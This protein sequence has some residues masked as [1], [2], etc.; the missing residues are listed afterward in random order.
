M[1]LSARKPKRHGFT[2]VELLVLLALAAL[3]LGLLLPFLRRARASAGSV[4]C[5]N[6]LKQI[7]LAM[8]NAVDIYQGHLPPIAGPY[9]PAARNYGTV[10]FHLLPFIEQAH[11]HQQA[12]GFVWQ[13]RAAAVPVKTFLCP[14]DRSGPPS[15]VFREWLAVDNYAGNWLAFGTGGRRFPASFP[16]GT[17]NTIVFTERYQLCRGQPC[18]WGYPGLYYWSPMF[19]RYSEG[20]FQTQPAANQ[21][22]PALPQS[23]HRGGI[24]V[25]MGDGSA[26]LI[27]QAI[28]VQTWWYACT[29]N[30]GEIL[31]SDF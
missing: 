3:L 25:A 16:D 26:R 14:E 22:N 13:N 15:Q 27:N 17:S 5:Q 1:P 31:G 10:L 18:A 7:C 23:P 4:Q 20:K 30:G 8:H 9:P 19:A 21:C 11:L 12:N 29:P 2:L 6:N 28:S 24:Q